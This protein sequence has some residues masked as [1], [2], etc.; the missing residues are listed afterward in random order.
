MVTKTLS[1]QSPGG[2]GCA[3]RLKR[4]IVVAIL[5][6]L[7]FVSRPNQQASQTMPTMGS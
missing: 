7:S 6:M 2:N 3:G 5:L 1:M 4:V